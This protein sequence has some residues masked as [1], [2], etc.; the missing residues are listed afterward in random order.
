[1]KRGVLDG[2][3][4]G[5]GWLF[6]R[7]PRER[8][9]HKSFFAPRSLRLCVSAAH[10]PPRSLSRPSLW[11]CVSCSAPFRCAQCD[12]DELR[13]RAIGTLSGGQRQ[14]ARLG[15]ALAQDTATLLLDEPT[16][17]LD[18]AARID[19]LD[20]ARDLNRREGRTIVMI[21]HDLN[22]AARYADHLVAMTDGQVI[23]AGPPAEVLT[24]SLLRDVFAIEAAVRT[25]PRTGT[26]L[27]LPIRAPDAAMPQD[28]AVPLAEAEAL[29]A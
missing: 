4:G 23:A 28:A 26:P 8:N 29:S 13:Y 11:L 7:S 27:I 12:L 17:F 19:P 20:L 15:T 14:R 2:V 1:M 9:S 16:T 5:G 6:A 10:I 25:D 21:L 24:V 18:I 3:A 22:L